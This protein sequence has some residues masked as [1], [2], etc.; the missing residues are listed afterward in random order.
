MSLRFE[1]TRRLCSLAY[2][3]GSRGSS[4]LPSGTA[5][6]QPYASVCPKL[7][8]R[9][10]GISMWSVMHV[11]RR[12]YDHV[13]LQ[14]TP[15]LHCT[16]FFRY[17]RSICT[18]PVSL[19]LQRNSKKDSPDSLPSSSAS[20]MTSKS[21]KQQQST[22]K[23]T[24]IGNKGDQSKRRHNRQQKGASTYFDITPF[25]ALHHVFCQQ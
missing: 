24:A 15:P 6:L 11:Q 8:Q 20:H 17:S 1:L 4:L 2:E 16:L 13:W 21:S 9:R 14:F 23:A 3:L 7:L 5:Y 22:P 25:F 19:E 10:P 18:G 12:W